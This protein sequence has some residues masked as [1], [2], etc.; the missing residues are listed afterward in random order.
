[1]SSS[2][3]KKNLKEF[4]KGFLQTNLQEFLRKYFKDFLKNSS[5]IFVQFW[6]CFQIRLKMKVCHQIRQQEFLKKSSAVSL[7]NAQKLFLNEFLQEYLKKPRGN[8]WKNLKMDF[9]RITWRNLSG[10]PLFN[11]EGFIGKHQKKFTN[12][13]LD[14]VSGSIPKDICERSSNKHPVKL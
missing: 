2:N 12:K 14:G 6:K 10:N 4:F 9:L 1:M 11:S 13:T 8:F 5:V 3:F 7:K